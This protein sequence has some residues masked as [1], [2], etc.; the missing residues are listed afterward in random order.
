SGDVIFELEHDGGGVLEVVLNRD[1][2]L[3][4]DNIARAP[5]DPPRQ[6]ILLAV[7]ERPVI[8]YHL[9]KALQALPLGRVDWM[10]PTE[11]EA[12]KEADLVKDGHPVY[13][14]VILDH[15][16]TTKLPPG[17]YLFFGGV[18]KIEGVSSGDPIENDQIASWDETH[19]VLRYV[20]FEQVYAERWL[21]LTLPSYAVP[22]VEGEHSVVLAYLPMPGKQFV[23]CAFDLAD[24]NWPMRVPFVVFMY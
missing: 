15:H 22:L 21:K 9:E 7:T 16:D 6:P 5:L 18:P 8:R 23:I 20:N 12:A 11:Y 1:D 19:P 24:S 17:G 10:T 2:A 3:E 14:L 13:D 4:T